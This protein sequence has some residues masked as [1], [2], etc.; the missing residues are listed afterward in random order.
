MSN[1]SST[2]SATALRFNNSPVS[3]EVIVKNLSND[4]AAFKIDL[5]AAGA[6]PNIKDTWYSLDP[7][8]ST[9]IP[10]GDRTKFKISILAAPVRGIDLINI[11]VEVAS[12][13]LPDVNFHN[14]KLLVSSDRERLKVYLPV[15]S[16]AIYPRQVLDIPVRVSN[17]NHYQIDTVLK[18]V[19]LDS[20]WLSK[21]SERRL[22][23][24]ASKEAETN[25]VCQ[26][27][28]VKHAPCKIYPFT[29]QATVGDREWGQTRGTIEI[30]P[31]GTVFFS[32]TPES[33]TL[34]RKISRL[35]S[36][37]EPATYQ[38]KLKNASNVDQNR[39][40][41]TVEDKQCAYRVIPPL[42][43]AK[44]GKTEH[45]NLEVSKKLPWWGLKRKYPL[46]ITPSLSDLRLNTTD[47]SS[48]NVELR[49]K[50][51]LPLWLQLLLGA[52][53]TA[54]ILWLLSL[55]SVASH[56]DRVNSVTFSSGNINP[57]L[58]ASNDG[59]VRQWKATPDNFICRWFKWQRFCLQYQD[60]L[61]QSENKNSLDE[62]NVIKLR[63]ENNLSGNI[64]FLG[65]DSGK[66]SQLNIQN[67]S[68]EVLLGSQGAE[69]VNDDFNRILDLFFS[70]NLQKV[71]LGQGTKLSELNLENKTKTDLI[72]SE[73]SIHVLTLSPDRQSIIA[74][75]EFN[76]IFQIELNS[77]GKYRELNLHS[78]QNKEDIDIITGLQFTENNI[79]VSTDNQGSIE[80]WNFN[81]CSDTCELID[82]NELEIDNG[83]SAI[84]LT[85][86]KEKYYL[87][88]ADDG[89]KIKL[90]S[91]A[92][93][94]DYENI[95]LELI[96]EIA[97]Y[98]QSIRSIDLV[99]QNNRFLILSGSEDN[100]VRLNVYKLAK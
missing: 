56:D 96:T 39:I 80:L 92:N 58:S 63:T 88:T 19:G 94:E 74:G 5:T 28:I 95:N 35:R 10:P 15:E 43:T 87:F 12:V 72:K 37:T 83:I 4:Y 86:D 68:L 82:S 60:I 40:A 65:F 91:F 34:S 73:N 52:I 53:A 32:V 75:G 11:E 90:W 1:I 98:P 70:P 59:T 79:L 31:I 9:L 46:K 41:I 57:V 84:A 27:P 6:D 76:K 18:L 64:A 29:I 51:I 38:L 7:I 77:G 3:F 24:G 33:N 16:F 21:G 89:G 69:I 45:L 85:K 30:L 48:Q 50:P 22:L 36:P 23:I 55:F 54:S 47:P 61:L 49:V 44:A 26:P 100:R 42:G 62:I 99:H 2:I 81:R 25:F 66:V 13:E 17:P 67:R 78:P 71:F 20:H 93:S 14:L 97:Q 8:S